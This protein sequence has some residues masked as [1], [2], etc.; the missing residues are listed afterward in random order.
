ML[1]Y[2]IKGYHYTG[3][4]TEEGAKKLATSWRRR[5]YKI[6]RYTS[7]KHYKKWYGVIYYKPEQVKKLAARR[8]KKKR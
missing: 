2:A 8:A 7:R 1:D 4:F 3:S 5:G 6:D